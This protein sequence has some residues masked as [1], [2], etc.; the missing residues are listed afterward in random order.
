MIQI[1]ILLS[2]ISSLYWMY[3]K[4]RLHTLII[5]LIISIYDLYQITGVLWK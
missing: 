4:P 5:V 3:K 2:T 1:L